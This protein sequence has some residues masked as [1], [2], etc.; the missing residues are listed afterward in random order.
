[1]KTL[2]K[3]GESTTNA[4]YSRLYRLMIYFAHSTMI[5]YEKTIV[6]KKD[7]TIEGFY[8]QN[9]DVMDRVFQEGLNIMNYEISYNQMMK[10]CQ[11]YLISKYSPKSVHE[12]ELN[13]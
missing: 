3:V 9:E 12:T 5:M 2:K 4:E 10:A 6:S 1:M 11:V 8:N 7:M 13:L